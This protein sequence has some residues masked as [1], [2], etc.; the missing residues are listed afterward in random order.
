MPE[1][2]LL[3]HPPPLRIIRNIPSLQGLLAQ[4]RCHAIWYTICHLGSFSAGLIAAVASQPNTPNWIFGRKTAQLS[5]P[6]SHLLEIC[7]TH[8]FFHTSRLL[9]SHWV[10]FK[11]Y[12]PSPLLPFSITQWEFILDTQFFNFIREAV[13]LN[14]PG[15]HQKVIIWDSNHSSVLPFLWKG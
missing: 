2:F 3:P 1:G 12:L 9:V 7:F 13:I 10:Q 14:E 11:E 15:Y 5:L 4:K 8:S 6:L